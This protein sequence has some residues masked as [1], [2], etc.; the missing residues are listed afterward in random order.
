MTDQAIYHEVRSFISTT[1]L[2][3][4]DKGLDER[5]PLLQAGIVDSMGMMEL[6]S[7][8]RDRFALALPEEEIRPENLEN[9]E[10]IVALVNR[11][12]PS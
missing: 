8:L 10:V 11:C 5:T 2:D 12:K 9:L 4:D 1:F 3:G 6:L 7:F